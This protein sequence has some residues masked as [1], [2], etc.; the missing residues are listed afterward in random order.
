M[1]GDPRRFRAGRAKAALAGSTIRATADPTPS[2]G[3]PAS[4]TR[5]KTCNSWASDRMRL[6]GVKT[7]IWPP[8][9]Q[10]FVWRYRKVSAD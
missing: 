10:G 6:A 4:S 5:L 8:F 1:G 9:V 3:R 2:I 7:S